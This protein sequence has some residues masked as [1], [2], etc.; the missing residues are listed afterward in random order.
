[1]LGRKR[2]IFL[3]V[4]IGA[5]S[6]K[7]ALVAREKGGKIRVLKAAVEEYEILADFAA[8]NQLA[9]LEGIFRKF[10]RREKQLRNARIG[11]SVAGQSAFVR[12]TKIPGAVSQKL[13]QIVLYE[14]QQ[15]IPFPINEVVW[16]FQIYGKENNQLNVLL[17][18]VKKELIASFLKIAQECSF[19]VEFVDVS[20]LSLYNC[21]QYFYRDLKH[22]LI[23]DCGAKTTNIM[24]VDADKIWTR[25]LP[26]GGEDITEAISQALKIERDAAERVKK[27]KAKVLM[28]YYGNPP[29]KHTEE[30]KIAEAVTGVLTDLTNEI[31][32][33]L[34]YYKSQHV[35]EL[36]LKK[37]LV[38]GGVSKI[39]NIDK[40]FENSLSLP[41]QKVDY[42]NFLSFHHK[43][44][45][46]Y[47]ELLG[48]ALGLVLRGF[49]Q[50]NLNINLLPAEHL[51][52]KD[53]KKKTPFIIGTCILAF[54]FTLNV[55]L[56]ALHRYKI[57]RAYEAKLENIVSSFEEEQSRLEKVRKSRR[58]YEESLA[59]LTRILLDKHAAAFLLKRIAKAMPESV[60]LEDINI[61]L[62]I[63]QV[64]LNGR[65]DNNLG[66]LNEFRQQLNAIEIVRDVN[67]NTVGKE[68]DSD[69]ITFSLALQLNKA[70]EKTGT[71]D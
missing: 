41:A 54:L 13:R 51:A 26:I 52:A 34:N 24:V 46:E 48:P 71:H 4:D 23:L 11:I 64:K 42:L 3:G 60:W 35:S 33:T 28:L 31:L 10:I 59:D 29:E 17:A 38:T 5:S 6:V 37:I 44:E 14:T 55:S 70:G 20:N 40:F 57:A 67:I 56:L 25:S 61:D 7:F 68:T 65:C 21:L 49:G 69:I 63:P 39:E 1:M 27:E 47:N 19:D 50:A 53:F 2:N 43:V 30:Q 15:Q 58:A 12:L 22:T 8:E 9:I 36:S 16:D 62:D 45:L 32:K 18:A 66:A